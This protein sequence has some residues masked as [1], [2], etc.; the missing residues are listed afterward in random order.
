LR[1]GESNA[2]TLVLRMVLRS[3]LVLRLVLQ[4]DSVE[5]QLTIACMSADPA[6]TAFLLVEVTRRGEP[7]WAVKW[8][9]ADGTRVKRRLGHGAWVRRGPDDRWA[10]RSG[11]SQDGALTEFQARRLVPRFVADAELQLAAARTRASAAK[12]KPSFRELALAWLR[13]LERVEDAKPSTLRD[14]RAL[15]AEPGAGYRRG[16]GETL[17]RIMRALGDTPTA[18]VSGGDV[19]ALL[20]ALD[21]QPISRRTVNKY[22]ATLHAI[23]AFGLSPD[24]RARWGLES[25]PVADTRKRRQD[26]AGHLEVF[27]IEQIEALARTAESGSWRKGRTYVAV[28][29]QHLRGQEDGEL[30]DF[31]RVAAYTGLRRGELVVLRWEDVSWAERVL[32]VRRALSG[33]VERSTKS[34][35]I[36]Y[37]PLADQA[38]AAL[39]R[40]SKRPNFTRP[41]DY[42]FATVA[43]ERPDPS[44]L[45]RRY[46]ACRDAIGLPPLRFHDLRHTAGSLLVRVM[47]PVTVKDIMG[48][49]DLA[50]TERYLHAVRATRLADQ[51]T[52]AFSLRPSAGAEEAVA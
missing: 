12:E 31:L 26:D 46:V 8:R 52:K 10:S 1:F 19:D 18:D 47:D 2:V 34:R 49:A 42:V 3:R 41:G 5:R 32:V 17:G 27:T 23:F 50:T 11:R 28:N 15:L 13:H 16:K 22:R 51:A 48:H 14:Y 36:R 43:G 45:R 29:T 35:R 39:D 21:E 40:L 38:L 7:V 44:A 20:T 37:V 25:N 9:S 4:P 24:Q 6:A 33:T 30:A